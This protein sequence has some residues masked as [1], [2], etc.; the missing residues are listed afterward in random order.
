MYLL[1]ALPTLVVLTTTVMATATTVARNLTLLYSMEAELGERLELVDVPT[2]QSR[3]VIPIVGGFFK[4]QR[5]SGL[6][7]VSSFHISDA[8]LYKG[9]VLNLGADWLLTD[10]H[11]TA[12]P[13]TRYN[14]QTD[15]GTHIYVQIE[16]PAIS[17]GQVMLRAKFE[18]GVN[19][20]YAWLNNAVAVGVLIVAGENKVVIDVW[21]I[22]P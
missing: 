1:H 19:G 3:T 2:G 16:G 22:R 20:T 12:R 17:E 8:Y 13:D 21:D 14:I 18:T 15:D 4:G 7:P 9:K 6:L 11:G 5:M 10:A